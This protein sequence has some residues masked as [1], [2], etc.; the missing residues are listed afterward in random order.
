MCCAW[1]ISSEKVWQ[2]KP[3]AIRSLLQLPPTRSIHGFLH[4]SMR[5]RLQ[6]PL[7]DP[8]I[9]PRSARLRRWLQRLM[10]GPPAGH[11]PRPLSHVP[12]DHIATFVPTYLPYP[13]AL[14]PSVSTSLLLGGRAHL[15]S[16]LWA[17]RQRTLVDTCG[18]H[19]GHS[20]DVGKQ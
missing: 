14:Q 10:Y 15:T 4:N 5:R 1:G 13:H 12:D 20:L 16:D 11:I 8:Q 7:P 6:K 3:K 19:P 9:I 18:L 2:N 17:C